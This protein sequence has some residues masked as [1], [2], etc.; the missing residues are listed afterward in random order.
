ME[1]VFAFLAL[2]ALSQ[3]GLADEIN[4]ADTAWI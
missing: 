4:G 3:L 2:L 1:R